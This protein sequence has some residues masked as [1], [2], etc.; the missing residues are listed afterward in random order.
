MRTGPYQNL[1]ILTESEMEFFFFSFSCLFLSFLEVNRFFLLNLLCRASCGTLYESWWSDQFISSLEWSQRR[2][3]EHCSLSPQQFN[4]TDKTR[5]F[6]S[7]VLSLSTHTITHTHLISYWHNITLFEDNFW[8]W[9]WLYFV[10]HRQIL[11]ICNYSKLS[12]ILHTFFHFSR[13]YWQS[14]SCVTHPMYSHFRRYFVQFH[15]ILLFSR[16]RK[17]SCWMS[18]E[19]NRKLFLESKCVQ[20]VVNNLLKSNAIQ[21]GTPVKADALTLLA[22]VLKD[23][24]ISLPPHF[25]CVSRNSNV[26]ILISLYS[27][28]SHSGRIADEVIKLQGL[29]LIFESL[30]DSNEEVKTAALAAVANFAYNGKWTSSSCSPLSL[31]FVSFVELMCLFFL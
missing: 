1:H 30:S 11:N 10:F 13:W 19:Q 26:H 12:F 22:N 23:G 17:I 15:F 5:F 27:V 20:Y 2:G 21:R 18:K 3:P 7:N 24:F 31:T 14:S 9:H 29:K 16:I 6:I 4:T 8:F 25:I 28:E